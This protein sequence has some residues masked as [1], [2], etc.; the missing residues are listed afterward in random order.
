M[1]S[2]SFIP[3]E[4]S[5]ILPPDIVG[6]I[7]KW[8]S[9]SIDEY[10][11]D[12]FLGTFAVP[13]CYGRNCIRVDRDIIPRLNR[14]LQCYAIM[15]RYSGLEDIPDILYLYRI[16]KHNKTPIK[17]EIVFDIIADV[18]IYKYFLKYR[19]WYIKTRYPKHIMIGHLIYYMR[20]ELFDEYAKIYPKGPF[21]EVDL[22]NYFRE[23]PQRMYS[24]IA[25]EYIDKLRQKL[26]KIAD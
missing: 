25:V 2:E 17:Y 15:S 21:T 6:E 9:N 24:E 16:A 22:D 13:I 12:N 23:N 10:A 4:S 7:A 1:S 14:K 11:M 5:V 18:R 26:K 8:Y 19:Q 3:S 20:D